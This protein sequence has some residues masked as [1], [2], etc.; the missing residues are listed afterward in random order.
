MTRPFP[1]DP[2]LQDNFAPVMGECDAPDLVVIEGELPE[3][4]SGS[5]YRNGPNPMFPPLGHQHHWFLGEG[6]IHAIHVENGKAAYTNRWVHTDQYKVQRA[7][8]ER[9]CSTSFEDEGAPR[10]DIRNVANTNIVHHGGKL[11]ALDEGSLP[12]VMDARTLETRGST[13]FGG[14]YVGPFTAHPKLDPR[15]GE[16][17]AFGYMADGPGTAALSYSVI[18]AKGALTRHDRFEAPYASM[19]H[20]FI[21]TDE[22][23]I[24][25]VFP[26]TIDVERILNGGPTIAW[27]PKVGTRI[28]IMRRD[29]GVESIR[30]FEGE[31]C[32]V[33]HPMNA[34]TV[35][36]DGRTRVIADVMKYPRVPLFPNADG[37]PA[38][39]SLFDET[40][41][42]VRW[43]FDLDDNTSSY[44]EE[45]LS[46][47]GGEFPR[48]DERFAGLANRRGFYAANR[49]PPSAANNSFDT[50]VDIDLATGQRHEWEP[51]E[52]RFVMEPV[53]VPRHEKAAEGNGWLVSLVYDRSRNL[54]DFVV[55]DTD[56]IARG[57]VARVEL[58]N[59]V[60]FGF[61]G[62]WRNN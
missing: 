62:N 60:P 47:L 1:N 30:W 3:G 8:G 13:D 15:T 14:K 23:V 35:H 53:F 12:V 39:R 31:A 61:H 27:D 25:P 19:V 44:R 45:P 18:D 43:T 28:G 9:L 41:L 33:Y 11:L 22:H 37:S 46:D 57:P 40:A 54:S 29:A 17:L 58:P 50:L 5:L 38:G 55:L 52:G 7:A 49:R 24:F 51:G 59:R 20:D 26:A 21:T 6:M 2:M 16:M 36:V 48:L 4:L 56:D 34:H 32:Y 10:N 42:L